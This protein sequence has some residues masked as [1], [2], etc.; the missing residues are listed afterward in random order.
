MLEFVIKYWVQFLLG[1]IVGALSFLCKKFYSLY[2]GEKN[3]QKTK[4]QKEFYSSIETLIKEGAEESRK[5]DQ[6]LQEQINV[7]QGGILSIQ[8]RNFKQEC[9]EFL[10]EG[11][12]I[13]LDEF[14][15]LQEEYDT[16]KSLG[17]N[18]DGDLLFS[19]VREKVTNILTDAK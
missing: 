10:R 4:E 14:E 19:M 6:K 13:S 18:H 12:D 7:M 17:G 9:R 3:H 1:L 11:R 15:I 5:G 16:Y 8:G 2:M